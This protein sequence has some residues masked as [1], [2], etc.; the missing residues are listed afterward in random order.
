MIAQVG[1][2]YRYKTGTVYLK[3]PGA[4]RIVGNSDSSWQGPIAYRRRDSEPLHRGWE[5]LI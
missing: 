3:V 1:K 4:V 2:Y 5:E